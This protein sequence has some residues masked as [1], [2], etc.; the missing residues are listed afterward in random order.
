[1]ISSSRKP[2]IRSSEGSWWRCGAWVWPCKPR[3]IEGRASA[4]ARGG[5]PR[6][7]YHPC[8]QEYVLSELDSGERLITERVSTVRSV[9]LGFWIGAGSR[10]EP[11]S[12]AGVT[13]FIEHLL[14]K[15]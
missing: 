5:G 1:M 4:V 12:K 14:F 7:G 10:D 6:E 8:V 15:G 2:A 11:E 9:A 13:H 3:A